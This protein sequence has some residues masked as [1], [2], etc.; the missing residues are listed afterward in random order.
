M[1]KTIWIVVVSIS[2]V[3]CPAG[4]ALADTQERDT[5]GQKKITNQTGSTGKPRIDKPRQ[6]AEPPRKNGKKVI[7]PGKDLS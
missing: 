7:I 3:F 4:T 2:L 6:A 1:K 5:A